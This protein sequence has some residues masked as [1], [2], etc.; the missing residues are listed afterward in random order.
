M[1]ATREALSTWQLEDEDE[2]ED[3]EVELEEGRDN[4]GLLYKNPTPLSPNPYYLVAT[5]QRCGHHSEI[6]S[7]SDT[8]TVSWL[9][10]EPVILSQLSVSLPQPRPY[11][12]AVKFGQQW[13]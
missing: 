13:V 10:T 5:V 6:V 12:L 1:P 3:G 8:S 7:L 9:W 11:T 4:P 2:D